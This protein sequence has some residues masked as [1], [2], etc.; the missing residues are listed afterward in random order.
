MFLTIFPLQTLLFWLSIFA[1]SIGKTLNFN[2]PALYLWLLINI[3]SFGKLLNISFRIS[4]LLSRTRS[5]PRISLLL[6]TSI[7][8]G[9]VI[10]K[11]LVVCSSTPSCKAVQ[12]DQRFWMSM[13]LRYDKT[14]ARAG[15][16]S[17]A[18]AHIATV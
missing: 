6:S 17:I 5:S 10:R 18:K 12:V 11:R 16:G 7:S 4:S 3:S 2:L 9:L 15:C 1:S 14:L 13:K 8:S